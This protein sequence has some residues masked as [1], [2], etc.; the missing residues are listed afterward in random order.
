VNE[1]NHLSQV[2]RMSL[3]IHEQM[4]YWDPSSVRM[5]IEEERQLALK[6]VISRK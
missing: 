6:T 4:S 2:D 3:N 1:E 5:T